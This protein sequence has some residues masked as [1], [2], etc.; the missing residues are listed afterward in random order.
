MTNKLRQKFIAITMISLVTLLSFTM[1]AIN[2]INFYSITVKADKVL[3]VL[4]K[5]NNTFPDVESEDLPDETPF[6]TRYFYVKYLVDSDNKV[7][8]DIEPEIDLNHVSITKEAALAMSDKAITRT[9]SKD[10][11]GNYRYRKY[12][13]ANNSNVNSSATKI[14]TITFIDCSRQLLPINNF[15][16]IALIVI[17]TGI[18][19]SFF[20]IFFI[21]KILMKPIEENNQQQ[22]KF[23]SNASHELKTPLTI[24]SANNELIEMMYGQND[25]TKTIDKE[26]KRMNSMVKNLTELS[27]MS[28]TKKV[29]EKKIVTIL[30][31]KDILYDSCIDFY[32]VF[33]EQG[34]NLRLFLTNENVLIKGDENDMREIISIILDNARKYSVSYAS[35]Y[36]KKKKNKIILIEQ[37][38]TRDMQIGDMN[39]I[40]S[41]FYRSDEARASNIEGSGIGLSI[42]S[43]IISSYNGQVKAF[44]DSSYVFNLEITLEAKAFVY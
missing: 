25:M 13:V 1:I 41:R 44:V 26:V 23:I 14:I 12:L 24:I 35:L 29:K 39:K 2:W 22:K 7:I 27:K 38:D 37:N 33:K 15:F 40:F 31:F 21:S 20:I 5:N 36:L 19:V 18:I 10:Y 28:D 32:R 42:L 8:E 16:I 3:D 17:T 4:E 6:D 34:K 11:D 9:K 43:E 30:S